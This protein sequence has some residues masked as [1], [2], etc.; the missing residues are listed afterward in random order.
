[1]KLRSGKRLSGFIYSKNNRILRKTERT[2]PIELLRII[3]KYH[4]C[5]KCKITDNKDKLYC[6][7][8]EIDR[9]F[10]VYR[11]CQDCDRGTTDPKFLINKKYFTHCEKCTQPLIKL[12]YC[13]KFNVIDLDSSKYD[14]TTT[15]CNTCNIKTYIMN[16]Y[17]SET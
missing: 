9:K 3:T 13:E 15:N 14:Y 7:T 17:H 6:D 10:Y 4:H 12:V 2:I 5:N 16:T 8:C 11:V 1:M